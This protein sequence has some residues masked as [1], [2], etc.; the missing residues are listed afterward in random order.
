M[1]QSQAFSTVS[2]ALSQYQNNQL[3]QSKQPFNNG[4]QSSAMTNN[5][6]IKNELMSIVSNNL[7]ISINTN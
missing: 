1:N 7:P 2:Q 6:N 4:A 5:T 3:Q